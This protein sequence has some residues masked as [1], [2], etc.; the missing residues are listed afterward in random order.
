MNFQDRIENLIGEKK[1]PEKVFNNINFICVHE[2]H[3]S[4]KELMNTP[5]PF[6]LTM[7]EKWSKLDK[8]EKKAAKR[9]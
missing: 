8:A 2:F 3:W 4:Y 5:I 6:V 9:R 1:S 7:I